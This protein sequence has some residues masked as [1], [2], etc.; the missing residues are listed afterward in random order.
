LEK[1]VA[2]LPH[3][4]QNQ[5]LIAEGLQNLAAAVGRQNRSA[6]AVPLQERALSYAQKALESY[7]DNPNFRDELNTIYLGLGK[8]RAKLGDHAAAA[9]AVGEAIKANATQV[10]YAAS[11]LSLC[12]SAA[13]KDGKLTEEERRSSAQKYSQQAIAY[14]RQALEMAEKEA[15]KSKDPGRF[16]KPAE[17]RW[18]LAV[19]LQKVEPGTRLT[20]RDSDSWVIKGQ[21]LH[22]SDD[23]QTVSHTVLF[24]DLGWI[25][26][27]FEAE[28][29]LIAGGNEVA[30]VFRAVSPTDD[31]NAVLGARGHQV[32]D[33]ANRLRIGRVNGQTVKGRWYRVRV[34]VRGNTFKVFLDGKLLMSASSDKHPRGCVG[35]AT[36]TCAARFRNIKVTDPAGKV[37]LEGVEA[38]LSQPNATPAPTGKP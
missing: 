6:E 29:E 7:P 16:W 13:E 27:D 22:Q 28:F 5:A 18:S 36:Y 4:P 20:W 10:A 3:L 24:G 19:E 9:L 37:L 26:Y 11:I 14:Y 38:T 2:E 30:L 1:L 33:N 12:S 8:S 31:L 25:D 32:W 17:I 21:E 15:A 34:E 23:N 35:L